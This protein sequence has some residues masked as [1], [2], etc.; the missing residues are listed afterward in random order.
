MIE[1]CNT[2]L[3]TPLQAKY[4]NYLLRQIIQQQPAELN[5]TN[6]FLSTYPDYN[7]SI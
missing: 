5:H 1:P 2:L 6:V 7:V 3:F 4:N